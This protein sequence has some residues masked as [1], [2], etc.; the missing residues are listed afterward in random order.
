MIIELLRDGAAA[1]RY[2]TGD[3]IAPEL[4]P[5]PF[6]TATTPSGVPATDTAPAD[7]AHHFGL[8]LAI[9][10]VDGTSFWGGRTFVRGAGPTMLDN[11]GRQR[12]LSREVAGPGALSER[13][14]WVGAGGE[15]LLDEEREVMA[16]R[17]DDGWEV[18]WRSR[19]TPRGRGAS[20]GS[21]QTNG[22]DGAFY[23]GLFWRT[24]FDRAR[25]SCSDGEGEAA[26][27]GST[28]PWLLVVADDAAVLAATATGMPWFVRTGEYV[29]F[30]PA[31]AVDERRR[32]AAGEALEV[33]LCAALLDGPPRDP[34]ALAAELLVRTS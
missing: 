20:F 27:H 3:G 22:R 18:H 30:G 6:L 34:A 29:G 7:H 17:A 16:R 25:V 2:D 1:V 28:S 9:P 13:L 8:S 31:V 33:D 15:E 12:V 5:R 21:P 14:V 23:G 26:A 4:S 32:L 10:D 19:L 24:A 11:H